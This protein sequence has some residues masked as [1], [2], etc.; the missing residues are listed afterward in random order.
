MPL[1]AHNY[2]VVQNQDGAR[3]ASFKILPVSAPILNVFQHQRNQASKMAP[4]HGFLSKIV[5]IVWKRMIKCA[6]TY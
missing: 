1:L 2:V 6:S 5:S 4:R 3:N